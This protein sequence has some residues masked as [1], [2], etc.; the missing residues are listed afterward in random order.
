LRTGFVT[1]LHWSRLI[2]TTKGGHTFTASRNKRLLNYRASHLR[3]AILARLVGVWAGH[4]WLT[5]PPK[6][7]VAM[8][9]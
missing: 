6:T 3:R 8:L 9:H 1:I 5:Q 4:K 7:G 2:A